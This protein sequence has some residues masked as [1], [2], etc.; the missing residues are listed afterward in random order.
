MLLHYSCSQDSYDSVR[1][2]CEEWEA[3]VNATDNRGY[4]ALMHSVDCSLET[5]NYLISKGIKSGSI[6][7]YPIDVQISALGPSLHLDLISYTIQ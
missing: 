7:P 6:D 3:N 4:N 2:L 5:L 1:L